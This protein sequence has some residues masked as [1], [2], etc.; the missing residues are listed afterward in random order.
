MSSHTFEPLDTMSIRQQLGGVFDRVSLGKARFVVTRRGKQLA[1]ILPMSDRN[2]IET[3]LRNQQRQDAYA[4]LAALK[5]LV[6]D[7]TL[8]DATRTIDDYVYGPQEA[9]AR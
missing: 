6:T 9:D 8:T 5:G 2:V 3:A 7:P 1:L 4:A